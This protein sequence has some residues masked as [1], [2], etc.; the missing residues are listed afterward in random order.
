MSYSATRNEKYQ[1]EV[2]G[3]IERYFEVNKESSTGMIFLPGMS[4]STLEGGIRNLYLAGKLVRRQVCLSPNSSKLVWAY[5]ITEHPEHL[6]TFERSKPKSA[7]SMLS[8][9]KEKRVR[10][11]RDR[12][13]TIEVLTIK[14]E[15]PHY[16]ILRMLPVPR[17]E[18]YPELESA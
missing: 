8:A 18:G 10:D 15:K 9:R 12:S 11:R 4:V 14:N 2:L 5:R 7:P 6:V 3:P 13:E 1:R 16:T 17:F